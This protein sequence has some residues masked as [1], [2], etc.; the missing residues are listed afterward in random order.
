MRSAGKP[1]HAFMT[2][3]A[4]RGT[5]NTRNF[6]RKGGGVWKSGFRRAKAL[7]LKRGKI[8]PMLLLRTNRESHMRFQLVPKSTTSMTLN[9]HYALSQHVVIRIYSFTFNLLLGKKMQ[10]RNGNV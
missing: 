4:P 8:G 1:F 7:T 10:Q 6:D 3:L 2:L 5:R 9:Y